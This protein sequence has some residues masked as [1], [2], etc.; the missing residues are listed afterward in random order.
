MFRKICC[1]LNNGTNAVHDT[2]TAFLQQVFLFAFLFLTVFC[3]FVMMGLQEMKK[4]QIIFEGGSLRP[5]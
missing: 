1:A 4:P 2:C 3:G 5:V